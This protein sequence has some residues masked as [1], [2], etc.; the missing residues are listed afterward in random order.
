M[1][2]ETNKKLAELNNT[3][4]DIGIKIRALERHR[5]ELQDKVN[6]IVEMNKP[7]REKQTPE[8]RKARIRENAADYYEKNKALVLSK[9]RQ[10]NGSNRGRPRSKI[11]I[12]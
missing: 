7:Q 2:E 5:A 3:I 4:L 11:E 1:N 9:R 6:L 8:E 10:N 12:N